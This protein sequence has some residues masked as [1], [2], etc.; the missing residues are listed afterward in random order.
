MAENRS[1]KP[2]RRIRRDLILKAHKRNEGSPPL[3]S[4][5]SKKELLK[6]VKQGRES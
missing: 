5:A 6:R 3:R 2:K 4:E 1:H